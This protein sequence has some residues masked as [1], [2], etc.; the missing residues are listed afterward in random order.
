[1]RCDAECV[2]AEAVRQNYLARMRA[3]T[4]S[5]RCSF[6]FDWILEEHCI[7]LSLQETDLKRREEMVMEEQAHDL[8]SFNGRGRG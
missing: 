4:T 1:M 2:Q 5:W 6:N 8:H 7:L 3:F